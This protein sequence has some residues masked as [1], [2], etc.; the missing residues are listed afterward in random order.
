MSFD[1]H[2]QRF[3]DG[4]AGRGGGEQMRDVLRP[5]VVREEPE[6]HL[7]VVEYGGGTADVYLDGDHMMVSRVLGDQPWDLLVEGARAADWV[8][9]PVGCPTC[10]T[11]EEQRGHLPDGLDKDVALISSGV[12]LLRV[13][14]DNGGSS[15]DR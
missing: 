2:L 5:F 10:I 7:A 13:I 4:D 14:R 3:R 12:E 15:R 6:H 11:D 1:V 8:I 9:L